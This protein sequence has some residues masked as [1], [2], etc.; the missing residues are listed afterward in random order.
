MTDLGGPADSEGWILV[1]ITQLILGLFSDRSDRPNLTLLTLNNS[2]NLTDFYEKD[3]D[4]DGK[5][6]LKTLFGAQSESTQIG[7]D[8][9]ATERIEKGEENETTKQKFVDLEENLNDLRIQE[10]KIEV[11]TKK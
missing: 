11:P 3:L 4:E 8:S 1:T 2:L 5:E 9:A 7:D 6:W 10:A